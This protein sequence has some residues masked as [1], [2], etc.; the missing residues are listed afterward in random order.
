MG[1]F[2]RDNIPTIAPLVRKTQ[3]RQGFRSD[4]S[5]PTA[6]SAGS[7]VCYCLFRSR[8]LSLVLLALPS[9]SD[10]RL[11]EKDYGEESTQAAQIAGQAAPD[12]W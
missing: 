3:T 9:C 6:L 7:L 8:C 10:S 11:D 12:S 2:P 5:H 4:S 1:S